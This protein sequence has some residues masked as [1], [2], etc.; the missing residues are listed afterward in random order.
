MHRDL[1]PRSAAHGALR[2]GG[3]NRPPARPHPDK[4]PEIGTAKY[5][6]ATF[7][8]AERAGHAEAQPTLPG[9][10]RGSDES[11]SGTGRVLG[12]NAVLHRQQ[13]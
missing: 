8:R 4:R 11:G 2:N 6:G 1:R 9:A 10:S 13:W 12:G 5:G 7:G 3:A